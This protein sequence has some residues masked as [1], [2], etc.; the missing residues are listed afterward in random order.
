LKTVTHLLIYINIK[1]SRYFNN[2]ILEIVLTFKIIHFIYNIE[3]NKYYKSKQV[4]YIYDTP[5][6][7]I[8]NNLFQKCHWDV[9]IRHETCNKLRSTYR[10]IYIWISSKGSFLSNNDVFCD[11]HFWTSFFNILQ[12]VRHTFSSILV[13]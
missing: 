12:Q 10:C 6:C 11:V 1:D 3:L 5:L 4:I 7:N 9:I 2:N 13:K 8:I